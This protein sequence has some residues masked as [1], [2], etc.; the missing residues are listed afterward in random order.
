MKD[1][2]IKARLFAAVA[3]FKAQCDIRYYLNGVYVEPAPEGGA[4]IVDTNGHAMCVWR[5]PSATG[6]ERPIIIATDSKLL[7]ACQGSDLKR[8]VVR[9]ERLAVVLDDKEVFI[10]PIQKRKVAVPSW[11]IEGNF[12]D[13][14]RVMPNA[15]AH[16]VKGFFNLTYLSAVDRAM[17]IG[18]TAAAKMF[19][20]QMH[21]DDAN[22]PIL[23]T[24]AI[25]LD[26]A[27]VIMP[28]RDQAMGIPTWLKERKTAW[29]AVQSKPSTET[30]APAGSAEGG[31]PQ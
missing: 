2:N 8:L 22:G 24:S 21:Q 18:N 13:W 7:Q 12:P 20:P 26:F 29:E 9:D 10:Q 15:P 14:V 5:D 25:D 27:A 28:V 4:V 1:L 19:A 30:A 31:A 16:G 6:I 17:K 11:E 3:V 23:V